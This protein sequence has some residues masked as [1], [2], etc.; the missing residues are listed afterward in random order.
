MRHQTFFKSFIALIIIVFLVPGAMVSYGQTKK[1]CRKI[2]KKK[3]P[4]V[5]IMDNPNAFFQDYETM[6]KC[7]CD[8]TDYRLLKIDD[9]NYSL[10]ADVLS[11]LI[12]NIFVESEF[13]N[14]DKK[15]LKFSDLKNELLKYISSASHAEARR[16]AL[17]SFTLENTVPDI[18]T[19]KR[20]SILIDSLKHFSADE[21]L[22]IKQ[23]VASGGFSSYSGLMQTY[24]MEIV[25]KQDS[26]AKVQM[27]SLAAIGE[28]EIMSG[29]PAYDNLA[30]GL[31]QAGISQK[32]VLVFFSGYGCVNAQQM[33]ELVLSETEIMNIII[34]RFEFV[35][36]LVDDRSL[37]PSEE[38]YT[39]TLS[40]Q[41]ITTVGKRN[42]DIE[43]TRFKV[44]TQ[45][46]FA[47]LHPDDSV[48]STMDYTLNT[49]VF[50]KFLLSYF[51]Q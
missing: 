12:L 43:M 22:Q 33:S 28:M 19:W 24:A 5:E 40:N 27:D 29:P 13:V 48:F 36:L 34:T 21:F 14:I 11:S 25:V 30:A 9:I 32:P 16:F 15:I 50:K 3:I 45:P 49:D 2:L 31:R 8:S 17:I 35:T 46:F 41:K 4:F 51:N 47:I 26:L 18:N 23:M 7:N 44:D 42:T 37:L 6:L 39:S 20:D 38:V 1:E 10:G